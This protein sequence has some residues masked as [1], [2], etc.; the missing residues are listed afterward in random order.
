MAE[1]PPSGWLER[2]PV[3]PFLLAM[4]PALS[5]YSAN[6]GKVPPIDVLI[7]SLILT[8]SIVPL[9]LIAA[10]GVRELRRSAIVASA[11][12]VLIFAWESIYLLTR[13]GGLENK[14]T[15]LWITA[16]VECLILFAVIRWAVRR[17]RSLATITERANLAAIAMVLVAVVFAAMAWIRGPLK[18]PTVIA[19]STSAPAP[20]VLRP[21]GTP[22]DIYYIVPDA[23]GRG[24]VLAD[25]LGHD[26]TPFTTFLTDRGFYIADRSTTNYS[27][28]ELSLATSLNMQYVQTLATRHDASR[29]M[30]GL[31]PWFIGDSVVVTSLRR[32]G[33]RIVAYA[34]GIPDTEFNNADEQFG[35]RNQMNEYHATIVNMTPA[36]ALG[37]GFWLSPY[38]WHRRRV[39]EALEGP[40]QL[41]DSPAPRFV[42]AHILAPHPPFL[43]DAQGNDTS[44]NDRPFGFESGDDYR[45]AYNQTPKQYAA[46]YSQQLTFVT[47]KLSETVDAILRNS[48][49]SS[50]IIIQ[51]DHGPGSRLVWGDAQKSDLIERLSIHNCYYFPD[52]DY[53]KL[54]PGI[55][56]VNSFRVVFNQFFGTSLEMMEDRSYFVDGEGTLP[57]I[58]VTD[59]VRPKVAGSD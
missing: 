37:Q 45:N 59:K 11:L 38:Y 47:N 50:I 8:G 49:R 15:R 31:A 4:Y 21:A 51:G 32:A 53:S 25:R 20:L 28:T 42:Y 14:A 35:P 54:Y 2:W 13:F 43:F 40:G 1:T 16:G 55:S 26:L 44:P 48:K 30:T 6:V 22:P 46:D 23:F 57:G 34:C 36:R 52:G 18:S 9:W 19:P 39:L 29:T 41:P 33:Y 58:D 10:L 56:P 24:D 5:I 12:T 17:R 3:H 27:K 7:T